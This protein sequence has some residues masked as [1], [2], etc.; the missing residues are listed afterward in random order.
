M[1]ITPNKRLERFVPALFLL[2]KGVRYGVGPGSPEVYRIRGAFHVCDK[3]LLHRR[4]FRAEMINSSETLGGGGVV[5]RPKEPLRT[6]A[7]GIGKQNSAKTRV[8]LLLTPKRPPSTL[9]EIVFFSEC[10]VANLDVKVKWSRHK[11]DQARE[12]PPPSP[13]PAPP[14]A[15]F[16]SSLTPPL[17]TPTPCLS[18]HQACATCPFA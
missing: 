17:P 16:A 6:H 18:F 3:V 7:D 12:T 4:N 15:C 13:P 11:T 9:L 8:W 5:K 14:V 10:L 1:V 2:R